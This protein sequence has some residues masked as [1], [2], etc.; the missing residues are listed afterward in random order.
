MKLHTARQ[1]LCNPEFA[2]EVA[3]AQEKT[4]IQVENQAR[5]L[6]NKMRKRERRRI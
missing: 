3:K 4:V 6:V 1:I 5:L 2:Q